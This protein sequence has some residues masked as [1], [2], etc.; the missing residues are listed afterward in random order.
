M[1]DKLI[2]CRV[3]PLRLQI[4]LLAFSIVLAVMSVHAKQTIGAVVFAVLAVSMLFF[5]E[6]QFDLQRGQVIRVA[7]FLGVVP[8]LHRERAMGDFATIRCY[9]AG[10]VDNMLETWI[11][12]LQPRGGR[13]MTVRRFKGSIREGRAG[14]E[15]EDFAQE[16]SKLTGLEVTDHAA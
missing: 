14:A 3:M 10:S 12:S 1:D 8:V 15:A 4:S 6:T 9:N 13:A 5:V 2:S 7:R 11:V 16:L